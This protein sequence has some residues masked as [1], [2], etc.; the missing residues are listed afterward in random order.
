MRRPIGVALVALAAILPSPAS[1]CGGFFCST[2]PVDQSSERIV[3]AQDE[4]GT[5]TMAVEVS[6]AGF[7]DDF[8][9]IVPVPVP[10]EISLGTT[11]LFDALEDATEPT[12][13]YEERVEGRCRDYPACVYRSGG[14]PLAGSCY[15]AT[16]AEPDYVDTTTIRDESPPPP[17]PVIGGDGVTVY[18]ERPIGPYETVVLGASSAA[19]VV[20]WLSIHGYDVPAT[21]LPLLEPYAAAGNVFVAL[22]LSATRADSALRPIVLRS[23]PPEVCLPIRLTAVASTATL[24]I[25]AFFLGRHPVVSRN[26][27]R[28][29]IAMDEPGFWLDGLSYDTSVGGAVSEMGGQA[30]AT[31][32]SGRTPVLDGLVLPSVA[33]LAGTSDPHAFLAALRDRR[34][35]ADAMLLDVLSLHLVGPGATT[36]SFY[37]NCLVTASS[38]TCGAPIHWDPAGLAAAIESEIVVPRRDAAELV[39]R[40]PRLTRLS[41]AMPRSAM[42]LDPIFVEDDGA[43]AVDNIHRAVL[44]THCSDAFFWGDAPQDLVVGEGT[45][46]DLRAGGRILWSTAGIPAD[47]VEYCARFDAIPASTAADATVRRCGYR[48]G[49][50]AAGHLPLWGGVVALL[51]APVLWVRARR[52]PVRP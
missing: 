52:R 2:S 21:A 9:W 47:P 35:P 44:V 20:D 31:D 15:E 11:A 1:A 10:P 23:R 49:C 33:D 32:Y 41:T 37:Y 51:L 38:A 28:V 48:T 34:F 22:R 40:H 12:W 30:F 6:Y 29:E 8:A 19:Q 3:Y 5:L 13:V 50:S 36:D 27:S 16:A 14:S 17:D 24:P 46:L 25:R 45:A 26:Y 42:T 43:P 7:D 39:G 4:D 18:S